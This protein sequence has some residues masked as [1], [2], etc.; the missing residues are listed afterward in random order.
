MLVFVN[1]FFIGVLISADNDINDTNV[2]NDKSEVEVDNNSKQEQQQNNRRWL[3]I[4]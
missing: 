3:S 4:A 2:D 1:F